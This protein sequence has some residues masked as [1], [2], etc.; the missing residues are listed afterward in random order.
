MTKTEK[1]AR[2]YA[3]E[4]HDYPLLMSVFTASRLVDAHMVMASGRGLVRLTAPQWI[5]A[6]V[7]ARRAIAFC[8]RTE[9]LADFVAS[10][11]RTPEYRQ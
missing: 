6:S 7:A 5:S 3:C 2:W 4:A 10:P 8:G 11:A 9:S 1:S